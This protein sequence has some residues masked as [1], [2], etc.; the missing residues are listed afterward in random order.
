MERG[1]PLE[2]SGMRGM[3]SKL[4]VTRIIDEMENLINSSSR[5][6]MTGKVLIDDQLLLDYL[7]R[8][9][10]SLPEE[11]RQAKWL[12]KERQRVIQEAEDECQRMIDET[13]SYVSKLA[14]E[15]EVYRLAQ[16][17]SEEIIA[18]AKREADELK[19]N[20]CQYADDVLQQMEQ[21]LNRA[22]TTVREGRN[23]LRE[24]SNS[25]QEREY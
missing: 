24:E 19:M 9:R 18:D 8:I 21:L 12:T 2:G 6:P 25:E 16:T 13:K 22:A 7:D 1:L 15:S 11:L 14:N 4:N 3:E 5:I 20:A 10:T 17:Q 23:E